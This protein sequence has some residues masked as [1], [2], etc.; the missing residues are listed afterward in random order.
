MQLGRL[1]EPQPF[2]LLLHVPCTVAHEKLSWETD[3]FSLKNKRVRHVADVDV[4]K[5]ASKEMPWPGH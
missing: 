5:L 2:C 1:K 4:Y 3:S